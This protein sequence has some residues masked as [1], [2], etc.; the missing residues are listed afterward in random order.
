MTVARSSGDTSSRRRRTSSAPAGHAASPSAIS[1]ARV[2]TAGEARRSAR[3]RGRPPGAGRVGGSGAV[4]AVDKHHRPQTG[5]ALADERQLRR[6]LQDHDR[7][8]GVSQD[9]LED[10]LRRLRGAG[11]VDGAEEVDGEAAHHPLGTVVAD[12][13]DELAAPHAHVARER[14]RQH[15]RA[16]V[17]LVVGERRE[18]AVDAAA[19]RRLGS[20]L[21][22]PSR[23]TAAAGSRPLAVSASGAAAPDMHPLPRATA[24]HAGRLPAIVPEPRLVST[25]GA[26]LPVHPPRQRSRSY[27]RRART[28]CD[29]V[30]QRLRDRRSAGTSGQSRDRDVGRSPSR[31]QPLAQSGGDGGPVQPLCRPDAQG[32]RP[33]RRAGVTSCAP[34]A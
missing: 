2:Y 17:E 34:T 29:R 13:G 20:V 11:H 32:S 7:R 8:L 10:L 19:Q 15:A 28:A 27:L 18:A 1:S 31:V 16:P 22:R 12:E 5:S 21:A 23:R 26:A 6:V 9:R 3:R 33:H 24:D 4:R 25:G 14:Q 30:A